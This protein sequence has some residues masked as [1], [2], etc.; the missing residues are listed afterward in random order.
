MKFF[1]HCPF[2][3]NT[4]VIEAGFGTIEPNAPVCIDC[5]PEEE[6]GIRMEEG[7]P[8]VEVEA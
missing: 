2:C 1:F 4:A 7:E 8:P 6:G 3:Q 5:T